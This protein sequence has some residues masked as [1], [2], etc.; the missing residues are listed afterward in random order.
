MNTKSNNLQSQRNKKQCLIPFNWLLLLAIIALCSITSCVPTG[1]INSKKQFQLSNTNRSSAHKQKE[2]NKHQDATYD[3]VSDN[4][5]AVNDILEFERKI[6]NSSKKKSTPNKNEEISNQVK[7]NKK[8][9]VDKYDELLQKQQE[10]EEEFN[11]SIYNVK[12]ELIEIKRML[13]DVVGDKIKPTPARNNYVSPVEHTN[14]ASGVSTK[15]IR[16]EDDDILE[17]TFIIQS[18]EERKL[19]TKKEENIKPKI[20]KS[21]QPKTNKNFKIVKSN[22][23]KEVSNNIQN[24]NTQKP[25]TRNEPVN[26]NS[27][28]NNFSEV[29]SNIEKGNYTD[30]VKIINDK[31]K[32]TKDPVIISNCNYWLG[33]INFNQRD[34]AKSITY[35]TAALNKNNN[36]RDTAQ[37]RIAESY[38]KVGKNEEARLAYQTLLKEHPKSTHSSKA[39]KMLQQL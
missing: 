22:E 19:K 4:D 28:D 2:Q 27:A 38:L 17:K 14:D 16:T 34:Y 36:K 8:E 1:T 26:T 20:E 7:Y 24:N 30:A 37:A 3:N 25:E 39:K 10:M 9:N 23:E 32:Q 18:E 12:E 5:V 29:V 31:L 33:E 35:F 21:N 6:N 11:E 13:S 15:S